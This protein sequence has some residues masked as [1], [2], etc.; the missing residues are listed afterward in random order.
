MKKMKLVRNDFQS[1]VRM[2]IKVVDS[3]VLKAIN[4]SSAKCFTLSKD[5]VVLGCSHRFLGEAQF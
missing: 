5:F 3:R 1:K 2:P 4:L